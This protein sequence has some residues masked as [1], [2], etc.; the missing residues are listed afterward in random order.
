MT[1]KIIHWQHSNYFRILMR[2]GD[3]SKRSHVIIRKHMTTTMV[4]QKGT[5]RHKAVVS[6]KKGTVVVVAE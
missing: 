4:A 1:R 6:V 5:T 3:L 2:K